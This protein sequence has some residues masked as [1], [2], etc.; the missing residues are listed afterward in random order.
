MMEEKKIK[1]QRGVVRY[2][3]GKCVA[4][5][6]RCASACPATSEA[7]KVI[8]VAVS[9]LRNMQISPIKIPTIVLV[10]DTT[11]V[12]LLSHAQC[13][14][15]IQ[16]ILGF[17]GRKDKMGGKCSTIKNGLTRFPSPL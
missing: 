16:N 10:E 15:Q 4:C 2:L 13:A 3:E 1:K 6:E 8:S 12:P 17:F 5:G 11:R 9:S 7:I 14:R